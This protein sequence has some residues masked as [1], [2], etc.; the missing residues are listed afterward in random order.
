MRGD[1]EVMADDGANPDQIDL[2]TVPNFSGTSTS[3]TPGVEQGV[4]AFGDFNCDGTVDEDTS[5][6]DD[7]GDGQTEDAGDCH[8][9]S[10]A[11]STSTIETCDSL[12]NDC[13]GS[14]DEGITTTFYQDADGDTY[15]NLAVAS[16]ACAAAVGYVTNDNDCDDTSS[17]I[18]PIGVEV[19]GDG[20]DQDCSGAD[21][22]S[23]DGDGSDSSV[24]CD[25]TNVTV[26][27][28]ATERADTL[29]NDCD[30][31][32][33]EGLVDIQL[34]SYTTSVNV[35]DMVPV[36]YQIINNS[37]FGNFRVEVLMN[38]VPTV[39]AMPPY[40]GS[41]RRSTCTDTPCSPLGPARK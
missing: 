6:Y 41:F 31:K 13:D 2:S 25:D 39:R 26:Y 20:I 12:D 23:T 7:D 32:E 34:V 4:M 22:V 14:T 27:P 30:G 33:D 16:A 19:S 15:G 40:F 8:D 9:A 17:A 1:I 21:W 29:D 24:D 35:G 38:N 18:I 28:G 11:I 3:N 37:G 5:S 36:E 10:A